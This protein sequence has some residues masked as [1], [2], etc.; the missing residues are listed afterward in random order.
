M[1]NNTNVERS[2][3]NQGN[4]VMAGFKALEEVRKL[5]EGQ[6]RIDN[7]VIRNNLKIK[8]QENA[9]AQNTRNFNQAQVRDQ[10]VLTDLKNRVNNE[11]AFTVKRT[12]K[13]LENIE[14]NKKNIT[15]NSQDLLKVERKVEDKNKDFETKIGSNSTRILANTQNMEKY[16]TAHLKDNSETKENLLKLS[17]LMKNDYLPRQEFISTEESI[18]SLSGELKASIKKQKLIDDKQDKINASQDNLLRQWTEWGKKNNDFNSGNYV[19]KNEFE[20]F[21]KT[22]KD[23]SKNVGENAL[24]A[25]KNSEDILNLEESVNFNSEAQKSF[26]EY[27]EGQKNSFESKMKSKL[28]TSKFNDTLKKD[29]TIKDIQT[30]MKIRETNLKNFKKM[31]KANINEKIREVNSKIESKLDTTEFDNKLGENQTIKQIQENLRNTLLSNSPAIQSLETKVTNNDKKITDIDR[32]LSTKLSSDDLEFTKTSISNLDTRITNNN[33]E[34]SSLKN[35]QNLNTQ[36]FNNIDSKLNEKIT[37]KELQSKLADY[38][39]LRFKKEKGEERSRKEELDNLNSRITD[40]STKISGQEEN[41][42]NFNEENKLKI[43][44]LNENL[45][46]RIRTEDHNKDI[47][48]LQSQIRDNT[49]SIGNYRQQIGELQNTTDTNIKKLQDDLEKKSQAN[50]MVLRTNG[51]N[52]ANIQRELVSKNSVISKNTQDIT[53]G[54]ETISKLNEVNRKTNEVARQNETD[55]KD[56][57]KNISDNTNNIKRNDDAIRFLTQQES[58]DLEK[59]ENRINANKE[60]IQFLNKT[61]NQEL[62]RLETNLNKKNNDTNLNIK[63]I[64]E[65]LNNNIKT[66]SEDIENVK[67][68]LPVLNN[69][70]NRVKAQAKTNSDSI[71]A[72]SSSIEENFKNIEG[73]KSNQTM[74]R[75]NVNQKLDLVRGD[76]DSQLRNL[77]G[78]VAF[79]SMNVQEMDEELQK[80]KLINLATL[81][82]LARLKK[83]PFFNLKM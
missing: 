15:T 18:K 38:D 26:K 2:E 7:Q 35:L 25:Q 52:I 22:V 41:F 54:L 61:Y 77:R 11:N 33:S 45:L 31:N 44:A 8:T 60:G 73:L 13:N 36:K 29:K 39:S 1:S 17:K 72:N 50:S 78:I 5:S 75:S 48:K 81:G 3:S 10:A 46:D 63:N 14:S 66:N 32:Q 40:N 28:D 9:I 79:N 74:Y 51:N 59:V 55:I 82:Q 64:Q 53:K 23:N 76:I 49:G 69:S 19:R 62:T 43:G 47:E 65:S 4:T 24:V 27:Y 67:S 70:T 80:Q 42:K 56:N 20:N 34:I 6:T 58:N 12:E 83:N 71:K 68:I 16:N 37:I 21:N 30:K 57:I